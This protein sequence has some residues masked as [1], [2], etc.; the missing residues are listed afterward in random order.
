MN[1]LHR[2]HFGALALMTVF[3]NGTMAQSTFPTK[4]VTMTVPVGTGG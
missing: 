4:T 1:Q 3:A 2:R